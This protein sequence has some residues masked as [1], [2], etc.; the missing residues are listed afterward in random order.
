M[1]GKDDLAG[2]DLA[3]GSGKH[4]TLHGHHRGALK[5]CYTG[6]QSFQEF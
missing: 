6:R 2:S 4:M 3:P 1:A 5:N